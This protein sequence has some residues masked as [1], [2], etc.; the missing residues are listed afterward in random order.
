LT[1]AVI[2]SGGWGTRLRPLTCTIP[3]TLIPVVNVPLMERTV[4]K[5]IQAGVKEIILAV[6]VMSDQLKQYFGDGSNWG[7]K[8]LYT[9]EK[10]PM[11]TAGAVKLAEDLIDGD[12]FFMLNGDVINNID[13]AEM[14]AAH[15]KYGGLG[16]VSSYL[17]EDPR[18]YGTLIITD[19]NRIEQFIE[20]QPIDAHASEIKPM[21]INAG[22]YVLENEILS[23]IEPNRPVS[24]ERE[25]FPKITEQ[26]KLYAYEISGIWKDIGLP[27]DFISGSFMLLNQM[28]NEADNNQSK[29][30]DSSST[31][32]SNVKI[33]PPVCIDKDVV[34]ESDS[35]IG[36]N[37]IIG[38]ESYIGPNCEISNS[39]L[40]NN[41]GIST[42][43][44]IDRT[45]IADYCK[46]GEN[47]VINGTEKS[48]V[49]LSTFVTV[50]D[51]ITLQSGDENFGVCH[52]ESIKE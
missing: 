8:I 17:V 25:V 11:G 52:H 49:V 6:S 21:P 29:L 50:A 30:I 40:F 32:G 19:Q 48:L 39:I 1:K 10:D 27:E 26:G 12:N 46:I 28:Y 51:N 31:I 14:L 43:V 15:K 34:I 44:K 16:T 20:K 7:I 35:N 3:K 36:P 4:I 37:V 24:I 38:K 5:L 42:N 33:I 22:T 47:V 9:N 45:I 41:S 23:Y 13:Y 2:L 18:R